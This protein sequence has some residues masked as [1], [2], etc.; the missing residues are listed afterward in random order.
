M[1]GFTK[2]VDN[3][4]KKQRF[5]KNG[6]NDLESISED[7][8]FV[9]NNCRYVIPY[10]FEFRVNTKQRWFGRSILEVFSWE[11]PHGSQQY[12]ER[13]LAEGRLLV[14]GHKISPNFIL[15]NGHV[16]TH[17]VHRH[18]A[19][20]TAEAAE[21]IYMDADKVVVN[22]PANLPVHPC[23]NYRK[24]S[25]LA[26]LCVEQDLKNLHVI[27]R[28]DRQ[29]SGLVIFARNKTYAKFLSEKFHERQ[30][31][32]TYVARVHGQ[33]PSE[34]VVC[35]QK[36]H[37]D[38]HDCVGSCADSGKEA[39]TT[40]RLMFYNSQLE[41]SL[42]ECKPHTGRTHQIRLHL[43]HLG[44]PIVNDPLYGFEYDMNDMENEMYSPSVDILSEDIIRRGQELN[45]PIC[46]RVTVHDTKERSCLIWLHAKEYKSS[47]WT[48]TSP[49]P[50]W[51]DFK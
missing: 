22:K 31:H 34:T 10:P 48:F 30:V 17:V 23:G 16:V 26:R 35:D 1:D 12:W 19:A 6:L 7:H 25:L 11:F 45:C 47:D 9:K 38:A 28:L 50:S 14:N 39:M 49:L 37:F 29:T 3:Y 4:Q 20:T 24:N 13:E 18:E 43:Q 8:F 42:V 40:F 51:S 5:H 21:I 15:Q 27:H 33:F 36:L 46:P 2:V 41:Q 32:K 44:H